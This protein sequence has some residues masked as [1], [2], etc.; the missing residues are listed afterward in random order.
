MS[1]SESYEPPAQPDEPQTEEIPP[2]TEKRYY[3]RWSKDFKAARAAE[4]EQDI[5]KALRLYKSEASKGNVLAIYEIADIFRR[6]LATSTEEK[7]FA[8]FSNA[9]ERF[10]QVETTATTMKPY[11]QY[12]IGSMDAAKAEAQSRHGCRQPSF[13]TGN[14]NAQYTVGKMYRDGTGTAPNMEKAI[15]YISRAAESGNVYAKAALARLY[16]RL[17]EPSRHYQ[18]ETILNQLIKQATGE[19]KSYFESVLGAAYYYSDTLRDT[20]KAKGLLERAAQNGSEY[21]AVL[22]SRIAGHERN[23][24]DSLL[25]SLMALL[26]SAEHY[27]NADLQNASK[28]LFGRGDLSKEMIA[29]LIYKRQDKE[30]TSQR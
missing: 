5:G 7:I 24:V 6:G 3:I 26:N 15:L 14:H 12:R 8:L 19:Q 9:L 18:A 4:R 13:G 17:D 21:A 28:F 20:A 1:N 29:E 16:L 27:S 25:C 23:A 10:M 22:L 30:N 2:P 11:L